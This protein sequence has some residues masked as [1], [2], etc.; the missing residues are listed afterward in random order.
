MPRLSHQ[1]A[2]P[3]RQAGAIARSIAVR[4]QHLA[5]QL[6]RQFAQ[7]SLHTRKACLLCFC[8]LMGGASSYLLLAALFPNGPLPAA[9]QEVSGSATASPPVRGET[10]LAQ[11]PDSALPH[12][13]T[14]P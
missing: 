8:L 5:R 2:S 10:P 14:L 4:Q 11:Q 9:P 6:S 13:F 12:P 7:L 1:S 3:D